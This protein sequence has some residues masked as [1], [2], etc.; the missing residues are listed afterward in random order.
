MAAGGI[1]TIGGSFWEFGEPDWD[2]CRYF[3]MF[4]C[5]ED[6][7]SN[8]LK[9]GLSKLKENGAKFVSVNPVR[10]G[11]SAIAD[12]WLG[13]RP[14]TD[15]LLIF[16][17]IH[18]LLQSRQNRCRLSASLY[19]CGLAGHS[20]RGRREWPCS[21]GTEDDK[22]IV[23][24]REKEQ[25]RPFDDVN[26]KPDLLKGEVTL[27]SGRKAAPVFQLLAERYLDQDYAPD[28]VAEETG[29]PASTIRRL[30]A[31]LAT[32]AFEQQIVID[33]PWTDAFGRHHEDDDRPSDRHPRH[34]RHLGARQ[35]LS[36][37]P[38]APS[39][40]GA[41]RQYRLPRRVS[42][43]GPLSQ[44]HTASAQTCRPKVVR[45][46]QA[47]PCQDRR[48]AFPVIRK[49]SWSSLTARRAES[50]RPIPGKRRSPPMA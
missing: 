34:A 6:H 49:I 30:A 35:R 22:P 4:G 8:P 19:Q 11:Y 36:Y 16:S 44:T 18:E 31:E 12:E 14:G 5:A 7:D 29:I 3:M 37:L 40:A 41:S 47:S 20:G 39:P 23:W 48:S 50:T 28:R 21:S 9:L 43:Q 25:P 26:A 24:D 13:I 42:L 33:Q 15:G 1:Y 17:I 32:V 27:A 45:S 2:R 10:T 38:S 46:R